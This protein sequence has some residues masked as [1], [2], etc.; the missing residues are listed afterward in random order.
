MLVGTM[1]LL[2]ILILALAGKMYVSHGC[3]EFDY[4]N[5]S[6]PALNQALMMNPMDSGVCEPRILGS[7]H[8]EAAE[9]RPVRSCIRCDEAKSPRLIE[10]Y[11]QK[12]GDPVARI[13]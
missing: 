5:L 2:A 4:V 10:H 11:V 1:R 13:Q 8:K 9:E 7:G 3:V 12:K 6:T